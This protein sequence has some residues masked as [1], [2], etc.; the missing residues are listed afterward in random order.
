MAQLRP[1]LFTSFLL[2]L[3]ASASANIADLSP[4]I[5]TWK[6]KTKLAEADSTFRWI[7]DKSHIEHDHT[8]SMLG[9]T[10]R[11][12]EIIGWDASSKTL[13]GWIFS[14]EWTATSTYKR[15]G[16]QWKLEAVL[17]RKD[18]TQSRKTKSMTIDGDSLLIVNESAPIKDLLKLEFSRAAE[19]GE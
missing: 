11:V 17:I 19:G 2:T 1:L 7:L 6:C 3:T 5:G 4:L 13:K 10:H 9:K 16:K 14:K 12:R 15:S 18:G 8:F